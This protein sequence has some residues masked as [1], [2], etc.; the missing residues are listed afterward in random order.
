G[1]GMGWAAPAAYDINKDGKKDLLIGE[2]GSG[3]ENTGK[4]GKTGHHV[5]VY[6]NQG[7]DKQPEFSDEYSYLKA[8]RGTN[9]GSVLSVYQYCCQSF[10]PQFVDLDDDGVM[11]LLT[12]Q[13]DPGDVIWFKGIKG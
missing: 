10:R 1:E 5:R 13:Y 11:D 7:T 3:L 8:F 12:G 2:F 4:G 6:L 9:Y